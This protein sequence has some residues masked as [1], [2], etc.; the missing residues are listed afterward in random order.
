MP[1]SGAASMLIRAPRV[2]LETG[3]HAAAVLVR[4]AMIADVLALDA[5]VPGAEQVELPADRVLLPGLVDSHV[6]VNEPGRTHWEGFATATAAAA[7]GG[8]TTIVDMPLNSIPPTVDVWALE[9]KRAAAR[10]QLAVDVAFWGGAVPGNAGEL[11]ALHAAGVVGFKCFLLPSG[12]DE[13]PPLD[14]DGLARAME[15]IAGFDGLLIAHAEDQAVIDAAPPAAGADYAAF[16]ASRP[17]QAEVRAIELL[18]E[19]ARRTGCRVHVVHLSSA[20]ALDVI[21]AARADGVRLTVETCPHYLTLRAEDVPDGATEFKCCPPIR[22][23]ANRDQ[24]WEALGEGTIDCIVS[25]HSPCSAADKRHGSGDFGAA[26]GGIASLQL[27]LPVVWTEAA[28]RGY[29]LTDVA[30][31]MAAAPARLC[32]LADRGVIAPGRRADLAVFAPDEQFVV[33]P[34]ALRHRHPITPYAGLRL[35]GVVEQTW[36]AG[37]PIRDGD[38]RGELVATA[39]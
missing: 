8:I 1:P 23:D 12:V 7:A 19:T 17:P 39:R 5:H 3:V 2:V 27:G 34:A 35:T 11:A 32:G 16:V 15:V 20:A 37:A 4:G 9:T 10:T 38:R 28:R 33:D 36:L 29:S 18:I 24:L 22:N 13:F 30:R 26:W 25:D 31:W 14:P 21:R 6:H